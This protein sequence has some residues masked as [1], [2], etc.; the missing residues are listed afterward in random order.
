VVDDFYDEFLRDIIGIRRPDYLTKMFYLY[1]ILMPQ[2]SYRQKRKRKSRKRR[3]T[4]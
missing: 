2:T 4:F 3:R 1:N